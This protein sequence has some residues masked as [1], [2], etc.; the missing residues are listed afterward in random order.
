VYHG[1]LH[2]CSSYLGFAL[3]HRCNERAF[4]DVCFVSSSHAGNGI[5]AVR[6]RDDYES[7]YCRHDQPDS[8]AP[9]V[10]SHPLQEGSAMTNIANTVTPAITGPVIGPFLGEAAE[11]DANVPTVLAQAVDGSTRP[12]ILS[13]GVASRHPV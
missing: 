11:I 2:E 9:I 3:A 6:F 4:T 7:I 10:Q 13:I 12:Y 1:K 8:N 5:V